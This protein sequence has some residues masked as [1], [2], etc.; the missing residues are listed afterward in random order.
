MKHLSDVL[1]HIGISEAPAILTHLRECH[2]VRLC[3]PLFLFLPCSNVH[4]RNAP[5]LF[6][7]VVTCPC[8][9]YKLHSKPEWGLRRDCCFLKSV[10]LASINVF[11]FAYRL[12]GWLTGRALTMTAF[13]SLALQPYETCFQKKLSQVLRI[14]CH[15]MLWPQV[16]TAAR[17]FSCLKRMLAALM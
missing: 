12:A 6:S 7:P 11:C 14:R 3:C 4:S 10:L 17:S 9:R 2:D 5:C 15:Y 1:H 16:S 13:V 8:H